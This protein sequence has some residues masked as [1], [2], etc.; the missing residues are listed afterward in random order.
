MSGGVNSMQESG[1]SS[2][3]FPKVDTNFDTSIFFLFLNIRSHS[4]APVSMGHA[5][6]QGLLCGRMFTAA[7][8]TV[9][10]KKRTIF[11]KTEKFS[12]KPKS[13]HENL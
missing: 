12:W 7:I 11:M 13:F 5:E 9:L 4:W 10:Y 3:G 2:T 1:K 8:E 6:G